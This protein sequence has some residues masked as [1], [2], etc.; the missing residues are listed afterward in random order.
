MNPVSSKNQILRKVT[1]QR[2][3]RQ[4]PYLTDVSSSTESIAAPNS[5]VDD[6][7]LERIDRGR[8]IVLIDG[9][10]L[11]YAALELG[12]EI[13]Y[14]RLLRYLTANACLVHTFFYTGHDPANEKQQGFL[15]WMSRNGFRIVTKPVV[16]LP[17]GSR[18]A[19]LDVE[20]A[21]DMM[22]LADA[23]DTVVLVSGDGDFAYAV[24]AISYR[25]VRV[26]VVGLRSMTNDSLINVADCYIDLAA[27]QQDVQKLESWYS[28][29]PASAH[30]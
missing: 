14:V 22:R 23:C 8:V 20:I 28:S 15:F 29:S 24:N 19:N 18:K 3:F 2:T 30:L 16:Q 9:S 11:F 25:G 1:A 17:D 6:C 21:V 7:V 5:S 13:D 27:I 10:N 12:I 4:G 26:E